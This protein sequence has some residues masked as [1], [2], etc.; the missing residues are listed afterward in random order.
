MVTR[1]RR[2]TRVARRFVL[3]TFGVF[4][5]VAASFAA[6]LVLPCL[7]DPSPRFDERRGV[8]V[9]VREAGRQNLG[10]RTLTEITLVS[11]SGLQVEMAVSVPVDIESPV[12]GVILL[13]G[14]RTGREAARL[15]P[16]T[17]GVVVA[18]LSYPYQG[19]PSPQGLSLLTDIPQIQRA[20]LDTPPAV[21]LAVDY[22][23]QQPYVHPR[24]VELVG[25]SL[26]AFLVSVPG[27]LDPRIGRVWLVHG[28]GR[29]AEVL[30]HRLEDQIP[31][32]PAR[33]FAGRVL[34]LLSY[35]HYL[36]PELWVGRIAPRPVVVVNARDDEALTRSSIESLHRALR[37]PAE[38]IWTEGEHVLPTRREAVARIAELILGRLSLEEE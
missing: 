11:S 24:H 7:M 32:A 16:D 2:N 8:L 5:L 9:D 34:A 17:A 35:S 19:D 23:T 37:E 33:R 38:I 18:A 3:W 15:V 27:A 6:F 36:K 25:V 13:G 1:L 10:S 21:L 26:G 30:A 4:V 29:P 22:L 31:F 14:Y 12:P 28:A 20:I